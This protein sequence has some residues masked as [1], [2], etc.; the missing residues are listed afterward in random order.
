M[1]LSIGIPTYIVGDHLV[2]TL[3]SIYAQDVSKL[4]RIIVAVD[5]GKLSSTV[6]IKVR[7][8]KLHIMPFSKRKGQATRIND[9][10]QY[11]T[12]D[13]L[14][15]LNDDVILAPDALSTIIKQYEQTG[16]D[17]LCV[18]VEPLPGKSILEKILCVGSDIKQAIIRETKN[19][20]SYLSCN[21][22]IMVLSKRL[23]KQ[24]ILPQNLIN[25]DA[26]IYMYAKQHTYIYSYIDKPLCFYRDPS[27][28]HEY[29][30]QSSRFQNS[31]RE[32]NQ[33]FQGFALSDV[34]KTPFW[35]SLRSLGHVFRYKPIETILYTFIYLSARLYRVAL[36]KI[37][38]KNQKYWST[39]MSTKKI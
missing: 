23:Y 39:D 19:N 38:P 4:M 22:R 36:K 34:Y 29:L 20:D 25:S 11:S 9:I 37:I 14:I 8:P 26:Y 3:R 1:T 30:H 33:Y 15:I 2:I 31:E 28:I 5:G 6:S 17:L 13:L 35:V 27:K 10:F 12:S 24:L 16:A 32:N 18:S 21:G 7:H